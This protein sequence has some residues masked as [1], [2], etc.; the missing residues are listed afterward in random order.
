MALN[1]KKLVIVSKRGNK[2]T[3][4][5][6]KGKAKLNFRSGKFVVTDLKLSKDT[7]PKKRVMKKRR[8]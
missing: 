8:R 5:A 7:K 3:A 6:F 4:F 2:P 1:V